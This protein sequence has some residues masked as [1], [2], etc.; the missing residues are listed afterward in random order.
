MEFLI[1]ILCLIVGFL[2]YAVCY[3][4]KA[5]DDLR[6]IFNMQSKNMDT[7]IDIVKSLSDGLEIRDGILS[8]ITKII[9]YMIEKET[10][11]E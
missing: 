4:K 10:K 9:E 7:V 2:V 11:D 6:I 3:L 5:I 8:K 1:L